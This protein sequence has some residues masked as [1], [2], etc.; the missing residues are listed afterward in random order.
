MAEFLRVKTV[1]EGLE[2]IQGFEALEAERVP[3]SHSYGRVMA[4]P[5]DSPEPIPH[6]PRATMDGYAVRSRDT[7]GASEA[8]P[9]LLEVSGE[10]F[11]GEA[12]PH[13]LQGGKAMVIPTGGMMPEGADAVV[14]VEYTHVLDEKTVE[15]TRPVAPGENV[16]GVGDDIAAGER[17][18]PEGW[19]LRPQD[20][21]CLAAVGCEKVPVVARPKVAVISTGDEIVSVGDGQLPLGKVRDMNTHS[22][23][24]IVNAAGGIV[25]TVMVL[26]DD[27][28]RMVHECRNL[29]VN[30]D[31][32][33]LSGGSSVGAR[34]YTLKILDHF[35]EAELLVSGVAI[36]PGKPT[37]L[38]RVGK[39]FFWGLP[40]HPFSAMMVCHLLVAPMLDVL[41][42]KQ[43][44][45]RPLGGTSTVKAILDRQLPSVHG[46]TDCIPVRLRKSNDGYMAEPVF[47]RS[48]MI[49]VLVKA[50]GYVVISEHDEGLDRGV[51]VE[52]HLFSPTW[53]VQG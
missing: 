35:A 1:R 32:I 21:A 47:G 6:F 42:G 31:V 3:L 37:I 22:L 39:G 50:D 43:A 27:L 30:H 24:G 19:I 38:A 11:M 25:G 40:G 46:R 13:S 5:L 28:E 52:V 26:E 45:H 33:L 8:L 23:R 9:A 4:M 49:S 41:Q 7:F 15:I 53:P 12:A 10:V 20:V 16:I 51:S 18:F 17:L 34:D 48:A 14:M 2:I 29:F 36:R 44:R